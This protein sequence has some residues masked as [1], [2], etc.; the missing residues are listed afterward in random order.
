VNGG[1]D[2]AIA[3]HRQRPPQQRTAFPET[4]NTTTCKGGFSVEKIEGKMFYS[5]GNLN[6]RCK[7]NEVLNS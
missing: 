5:S 2:N 3:E 7:E 1:C 6:G 4:S